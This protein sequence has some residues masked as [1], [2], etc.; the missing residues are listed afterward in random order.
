MYT[1][2]AYGLGIH[3]ALAL[4]ELVAD[5]DVNADVVIRC[6]PVDLPP[7]LGEAQ[8]GRYLSPRQ[9]YFWW[10]S[11]GAF[12]VQ[13]GREIVIAPAPDADEALIRLPLLGMVLAAA[14]HQRGILSL[15]ASAVAVNGQA[16][17]FLG[18][19]GQGKST[20]AARLYSQGH[21]LLTDDLMALDLDSVL[22]LVQPGCP[23][24]KLCLAGDA[25]ST[26]PLVPGFWKYGQRADTRFSCQPISL[27]RGYFLRFGERLALTPLS[28]QAAMLELMTQ[29]YMARVFGR[30]LDGDQAA[31]HFRQC[32]DLAHRVPFYT[33]ERPYALAA[34][35]GAV[36]L[37]EAA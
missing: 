14:L 1:Y 23:Q 32:A 27:G 34:L 25:P 7:A 21:R 5:G 2:L 29:S 22:P 18:P 15:H 24:L 3:S 8:G 13:D 12:L 17:A 6:G 20:L 26:P 16:V 33:L 9:A 31:R 36:A 37:I 10:A 4:P 35:P 19:K 11:V 30:A 28:P